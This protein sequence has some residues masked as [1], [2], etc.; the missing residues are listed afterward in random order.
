M[1][2]DTTFGSVLSPAYVPQFP[3][4][5]YLRRRALDLLKERRP[6]P[7]GSPDYDY[8]TRAAWK[9]AQWAMGKPSQLWTDTPG[10]NR[11]AL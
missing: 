8:R 6:Y 11:H 5:P 2:R 3:G 4:L 7:K 10:E 1:P 9:L